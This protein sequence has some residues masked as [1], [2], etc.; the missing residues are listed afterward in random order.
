MVYPPEFV[1]WVRDDASPPFG[2]A[3]TYFGRGVTRFKQQF[4][5][6]GLVVVPY[7]G[8]AHNP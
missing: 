4:G 6:I 8:P 1:E 7:S 2:Q 3:F 5:P